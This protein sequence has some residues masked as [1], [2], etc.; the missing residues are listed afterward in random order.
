MIVRVSVYRDP[1]RYH[2][3]KFIIRN[4]TKKTQTFST[5]ADGQNTIELRSESTCTDQT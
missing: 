1:R 3:P 4:T 2:D 5:G